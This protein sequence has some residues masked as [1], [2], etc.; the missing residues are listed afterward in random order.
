MNRMC[1]ESCNQIH[2]R[3][4]RET[5]GEEKKR[6]ETVVF[7]SKQ[8]F[9]FL[10]FLFWFVSLPAVLVFCSFLS[11]SSGMAESLTASRA[12]LTIILLG[13]NPEHRSSEYW[14]VREL[15]HHFVGAQLRGKRG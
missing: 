2:A 5:P 9:S 4:E 11:P 10:F 13:E 3:K 15:Q 14:R 8:F 12:C 7:F 1:L 6:L